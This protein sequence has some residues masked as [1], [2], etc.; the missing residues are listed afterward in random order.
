MQYRKFGKLDWEVSALGFGCMRLPVIDGKMDSID[1]PQAIGMV[2]HAIDNGLNYVDTAY[3][4]HE[5]QSESFVGRMLKDGYRKK[6]RLATK[7]PAW[8]IKEKT[9]FDRYFNEQ[10]ERLQTDHLDLYLLHSMSGTRWPRLRD[11]GVREWAEKAIA[12]GRIGA[13]G[14]SFHDELPAFKQIVDDYDKWNFCQI[15]Y[16]Y[17]DIEHQAG[18]EGLKYAASKG[19]AVVIMEPLLGGALANSP[20][21]VEK[22]FKDADPARTPADWALQ[23]LWDQPEISVVLSGMSTPE[24]VDQN[25]ASAGRSKIGNMSS[26]MQSVIHR[27]RATYEMLGVI[28]CTKCLYCQPCPH[29]V[30]I[31]R[32]FELFNQGVLTGQYWL[33]RDLY[34]H[35]SDGERASN[36]EDCG[37]CEEVCPQGI[38]TSDWMPYLHEVLGNEK[39]YD[40]RKLPKPA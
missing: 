11:L 5:G 28:P 34:R 26:D 21:P 25:I 4:Y 35:L 32:I 29:G 8:L 10:L 39:E 36:C 37:E 38:L 17:L 23:W 19:L 18:T 7:M 40:G 27:A 2:R 9:D 33:S 24:Q 12:G 22:I 20:E 31:P 15:Q 30:V 13:I 16:N 1:D 3:A 6:V 14:F